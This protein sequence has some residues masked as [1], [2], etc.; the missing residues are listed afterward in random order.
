MSPGARVT[1]LP[2]TVRVALSSACPPG[3]LA[4]HTYTP[5]AP[6]ASSGILRGH[7][8]GEGP[9]GDPGWGS[10]LPVPL[11]LPQH[12]VP[13]TVGGGQ[14]P[15][16]LQ[17]LH[18]GTGVPGD[19]AGKF[20]GATHP[21][22]E[23]PWC[24][25]HH[26]GTASD[27]PTFT[28]ITWKGCRAPVVPGSSEQGWGAPLVPSGT[29]IIHGGR[30]APVVPS[31]TRITCVGCR[32]PVVPNGTTQAG[33]GAPVVPVSTGIVWAGR[34]GHPAA[35][36]PPNAEHQWYPGRGWAH[37]EQPHGRRPRRCQ[38]GW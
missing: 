12:P 10:H 37:H 30:R 27:V 14:L 36:P 28:S 29:C 23:A 19:R 11:S 4:R 31:N 7:S 6:A 13:H 17:P 34:R 1:L 35:L 3:A 21:L 9:H 33:W 15:T 2:W 22:D 5:C 18:T 26:Q 25:L 8:Q 38:R 20:G 24:H 16:F 32:P